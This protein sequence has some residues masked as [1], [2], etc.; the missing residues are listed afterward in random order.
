MV[1]LGEHDLL[2]TKDGPH[3]DIPIA[4]IRAHKAYDNVFWLNDIAMIYLSR[5]VQ[6]TG[7][8]R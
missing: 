6:F 5:D 1:R 8:Y 4:R 7:F 2:T 3:Q